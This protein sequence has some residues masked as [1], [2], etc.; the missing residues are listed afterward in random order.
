M[1]CVYVF[2]SVIEKLS[3]SEHAMLF[4]YLIL[5]VVGLIYFWVKK[6]Y[7]YWNERGFLSPPSKF[8]FGSLEGA[9]FKKNPCEVTDDIYQKYK[10]KAPAVG[11]Y[12]F[13]DPTV[14]LID[15]ELYKNVFVRDFSSFHDRA[16]YY[17]K[18]DD[19]L[20]AK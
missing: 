11:T 4:L 3:I 17:N 20:S 12:A 15:P 8:P 7:N 9:G 13:F 18:K 16:F 10:G 19:P 1:F 6:R 14:L 5:S 2:F